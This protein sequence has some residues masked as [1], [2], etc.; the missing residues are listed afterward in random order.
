[1]K[2][3]ETGFF[4]GIGGCSKPFPAFRFLPHGPFPFPATQAV[5]AVAV[6]RLLTNVFSCERPLEDESFFTSM[7]SL[8]YYMLNKN[9]MLYKIPDYKVPILAIWVVLKINIYVL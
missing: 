3:V 6:L 8:V 4:I 5:F 7:K 1:M 2:P 9:I